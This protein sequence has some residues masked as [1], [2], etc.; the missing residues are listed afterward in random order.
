MGAEQ[1]RNK[2]VVK[3]LYLEVWNDGNLAAADELVHEKFEDH[4]PTRFWDLGLTG[5]GALTEA[6][7]TFHNAMPDFH[8]EREH[9]VAEGDRVVYLGK[10]SGTHQGPLFGIPATGKRMEVWGVN[11]FRMEDGKVRERWGQFD[12]L[13]M[14]QQLGLAPAPGGPPPGGHED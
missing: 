4:P 13:T 12:V 14:M 7:A 11:F 5:P 2:E 3:R 6:V 8:D 1:D 9:I 10:I